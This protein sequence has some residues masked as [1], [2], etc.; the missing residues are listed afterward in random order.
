MTSEILHVW[1]CDHPA[2]DAVVPEKTEGWTNAIYTHG[3]PAHGDVVAAHKAD[4]TYHTHGRGRSEKTTWF[5]RCGCGWKPSPP[6]SSGTYRY[7][8]EQH[9]AHVAAMASAP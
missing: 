5:M 6:Y 9:R 4:L 3:C 2:C 7:M 8:E 1:H